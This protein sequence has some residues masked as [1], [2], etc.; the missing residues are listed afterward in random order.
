MNRARAARAVASIGPVGDVRRAPGTA[1]SLAGLLSGALLMRLSPVALPSAILVGLPAGVLA[2]RRLPDAVLDPGWIVVDEVVGQWVA[3]LGLA[4]PTIPG[5]LAAFGLF[6]LLD[7][8][9]PGPVGWADRRKDAVGVMLDD[10][11]AGGV[12]AGLLLA[13]RSMGDRR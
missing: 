9:K 7:I 13:A 1:G 8:I 3:M 6:R 11:V 10:L 4:R 12:A 5:L 2:V